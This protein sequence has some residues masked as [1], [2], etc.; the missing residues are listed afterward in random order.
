MNQQ[1]KKKLPENGGEQL[2]SFSDEVTKNKIKRH[3]T[4]IG[5]VITAKKRTL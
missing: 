4:D 3:L 2:Y 5:D 1:A